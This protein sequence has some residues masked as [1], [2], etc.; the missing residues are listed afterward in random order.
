[1]YVEQVLFPRTTRREAPMQREA[2]PRGCARRA[3]RAAEV[4]TSHTRLA[5]MVA[6]TIFDRRELGLRC[7]IYAMRPFSNLNTHLSFIPPFTTNC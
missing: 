6:D 5:Q 1:M 4:T 2:L 3:P 7:M